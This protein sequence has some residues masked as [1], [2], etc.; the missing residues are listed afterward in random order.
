VKKKR[1][2]IAIL[3]LA[4]VCF[5]FTNNRQPQIELIEIHLQEIPASL[6]GFKIV[7]LSDLHLPKNI[8]HAETILQLVSEQMPDLIVMTGDMIDVT[9]DIPQTGLQ[10]FCERLVQIADVYAVSGNHEHWNGGGWQRVLKDS[11]VY[12]ID[13]SSVTVNGLT[14]VGI[15]DGGRLQKALLGFAVLLSHRPMKANANLI[16]S[17]HAHGGYFKIPLAGGIIAPDQGL[18]PK[19][20]SGLYDLSANSKLV[21]SRGLG[22]SVIPFRIN[23]R[24][25]IPVVILRTNPIID[26]SQNP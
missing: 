17:G 3:C 8:T 1:I 4:V 7:H 20:T 26:Q 9:A 5:L 10:Q 11:G 18:F 15:E 21:V 14:L 2:L 13:N 16:L 24:P 23:N 12:V 22:N 25:H 19:Y 6:D